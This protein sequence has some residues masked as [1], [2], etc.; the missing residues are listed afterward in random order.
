MRTSLE[1][2]SFYVMNA[3][4]DDWESL[5]QIMLDVAEFAEVADRP[6]VAKL[7]VDLLAEGL[8]E[9]MKQCP[10]TPKMI[11]QNPIEYWFGMTAKGRALWQTESQKHRRNS[12]LD[13]V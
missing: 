5:D 2:L 9:E 6:R 1:T 4:A 13:G 8:L 12:D 11:I 10:V 3:T 7:I